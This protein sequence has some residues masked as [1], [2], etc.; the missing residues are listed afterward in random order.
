VRGGW[1]NPPRELTPDSGCA[2]AR[3]CPPRG[4]GGGT[5][6]ENLATPTLTRILRCI[7]GLGCASFQFGR[8]PETCPASLPG[9]ASGSGARRITL[10]RILRCISG[11]GCASFQ[12]GR[13]PETCPASLPG[14]ASGRG[15]RRI[16]SVSPKISKPVPPPPRTAGPAGMSGGGGGEGVVGRAHPSCR[17]ARPRSTFTCSTVVWWR[18]AVLGSTFTGSTVVW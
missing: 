7:S 17:S 3:P 5:G 13:A 11:L 8:A 4:G 12:F 15:A 9:T 14:T 2:R 10:T 1:P 18:F 6:F 16:T